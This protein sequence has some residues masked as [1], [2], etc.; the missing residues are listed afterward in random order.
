VEVR[1]MCMNQMYRI[2]DIPDEEYKND[3]RKDM[4]GDDLVSSS[5]TP[6]TYIS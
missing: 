1:Q 5:T 6:T 2:T 4:P 3:E